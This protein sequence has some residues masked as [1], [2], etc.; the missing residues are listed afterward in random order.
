MG[1]SNESSS[2]RL[3]YDGL[4]LII[5]K[6][7]GNQNRSST[8]RTYLNIWRLFN[9]FLIR[10]DYKP[11][12]WEERTALFVAYQVDRG[13]QSGSVKSYISAI[14]K[15]L[16]NDGYNWDDNK[17]LLSSLTRACK[18]VNDRI[19]TRLPIQC[20]L[21]EL[22]LFEIDRLYLNLNQPYLNCMYKALFAIS[23]YGLMRAG[24]VT[25]S[26]HVVKAKDVHVG[27]N[28]DKIMLVLYTSKTH[29]RSSVPQKIR[30]T[31]N[32]TE[33]TGNYAK[34]HFCPFSLM[35]QYVQMRPEYLTDD[36]QFF[37]FSDRTPVTADQARN[38]LRKILKILGLNEKLYDLHSARIGRTNDLRKFQYSIEEIRRLGRWKSS[39]VYRYLRP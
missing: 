26:P 21:L 38:L 4:N 25:E 34:R 6:L 10:L 19:K 18:I 33:R 5:E 37:I 7:K 23:Y 9:K 22:I 31:S 16:L 24:E 15:T 35:N 11:S 32:K 12:S 8:N 27:I 17:V 3:S 13:M 2:S 20:G 30:I 14:K 1:S 29:D 28:K 36:E 39:C